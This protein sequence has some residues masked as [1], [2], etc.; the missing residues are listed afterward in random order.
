MSDMPLLLGDP[1]CLW[2]FDLCPGCGAWDAEHC[3]QPE[4]ELHVV[5]GCHKEHP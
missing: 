4:C 1:E 2:W 3:C 5:L